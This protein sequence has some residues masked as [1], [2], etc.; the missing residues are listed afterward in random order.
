MTPKAAESAEVASQA[1]PVD[2]QFSDSKAVKPFSA[3]TEAEIEELDCDFIAAQ[4]PATIARREPVS[5]QA[6]RLATP[7]SP[8]RLAA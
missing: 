7:K 6:S 4:K 1:G 2:S 5:P 8:L 3:M